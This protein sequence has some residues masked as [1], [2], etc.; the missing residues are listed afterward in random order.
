MQPQPKKTSPWVWV[1]LGCGVVFLGL[2]AFVAFI[3][4]VVFGAMRS[5]EPYKEAMR[6][7]QSDP[8]VVA[9][10]GTPIK[11]GMFVSGNIQTQNNEGTAKLDIPLTGPKGSA[12]LH[13]EATKTR[14][15]WDYNQMIVTPKQGAEI[16]LM[17][18]PEGSTST[19]PPAG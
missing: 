1:G 17:T 7:A 13:V 19:A 2:I 11:P 3:V 16:D 15:R 12:T 8:R 10:L 5:S 6:R 18:S 4:I 9:A 14:G